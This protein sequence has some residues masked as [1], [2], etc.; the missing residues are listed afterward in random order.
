MPKGKHPRASAVMRLISHS[1]WDGECL[2]WTRS[3]SH[4]GYGR[5]K[6]NGSKKNTYTHRLAW[7]LFKGPIPNGLHVLHHCDNPPCWWWGHLYLG[8]DADNNRDMMKRGR[9]KQ[10]RGSRNSGAKI[11]KKA[12]L[13]IRRRYSI[14]G[15]TQMGLAVEFGISQPQ[16][17]S[18]IRRTAWAHVG[19]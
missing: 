14:G 19:Q 6:I 4:D 7:S 8:T 16:V 5:M 12:V 9:N 3:C 10:P 17:S 1:R 18:I 11:T 13:A 2:V 15:E